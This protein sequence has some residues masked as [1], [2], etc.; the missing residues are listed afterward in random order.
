[1]DQQRRPLLDRLEDVEGELFGTSPAGPLS[2]Y[3]G[4]PALR[5]LV[6]RHW[7]EG[8]PRG[9]RAEAESERYQAEAAARLGALRRRLE[10]GGTEGP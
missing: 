3:A 4:D 6:G 9:E 10:Q 7:R 8:R 2:A 5:E 1:V